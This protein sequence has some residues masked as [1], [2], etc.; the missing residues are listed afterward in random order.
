MIFCLINLNQINIFII[1]KIRAAISPLTGIVNIQAAQ[2][3]A[4]RGVSTLVE[5]I[6]AILFAES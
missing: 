5:T 1:K 4:R 3:T 2:I 6:V